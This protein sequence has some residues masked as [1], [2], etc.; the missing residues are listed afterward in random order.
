MNID[1]SVI[2]P[3]YNEEQVIDE[4]YQRLKSVLENLKKEYEIIFINDCSRDKTLDKLKTIAQKD[5]R[6]K[7]ISFKRNFGQTAALAAG[8]D[9]ASADI[10]IS[11]DGD[12]QHLPEDIP[13]LIAKMEEGNYDIVTGWREERQDNFLTRKLPSQIAN[14]LIRLISGVKIHDFG[15][16][17][18][19]YKKSIIEQL[20]LYGE[21]HRF[22]PALAS[23]Y[24]LKINEIPI[25]NPKRK[26]GK[27]NYGLNRIIKVIIDLITVKFLISYVTKPLQF[28]GL[29]G[30]FFFGTGFF[31]ALILTI[32]WLFNYLEMPDNYGT[33]ILAVFFMLIGLQ[34]FF[35]GL[36]TEINSR[37]YMRT[38]N[39]KPYFI[40]EK[41][42]F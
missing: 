13:R 19:I 8:F 7:I 16:T 39:K 1:L 12:L 10:I 23:Q 6:V 29:F 28:F 4:L 38:S 37:I 25:S 20:E 21:L 24:S 32:L 3:L 41:I 27:S 36:N 35:V 22:I 31:I 14:Y 40:E 42:N 9:Y 5:R 2:I 11:M 34:I 30:L 17:L 33:L 18:R 15:T 26:F